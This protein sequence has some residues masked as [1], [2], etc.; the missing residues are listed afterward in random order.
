MTNLLHRPCSFL[1]APRG[2]NLSRSPSN[3]PRFA[4]DRFLTAACAACRYG[5][6]VGR[7][8]N[9]TEAHAMKALALEWNGSGEHSRC[10]GVIVAARLSRDDVAASLAVR[11]PVVP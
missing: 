6:A 11:H 1:R 10:A 3:A 2:P 5:F 9:R 8:I 4:E 7:R